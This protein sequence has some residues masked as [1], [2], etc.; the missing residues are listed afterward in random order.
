MTFQDYRRILI[1]WTNGLKK[2]YTHCQIV[3]DGTRKGIKNERYEHGEEFFFNL[4]IGS[5]VTSKNQQMSI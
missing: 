3:D 1:Y 4:L 5:S 2:R